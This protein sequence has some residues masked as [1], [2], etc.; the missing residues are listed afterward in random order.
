R[1]RGFRVLTPSR[2]RP[3]CARGPIPL[4]S[5]APNLAAKGPR[6]PMPALIPPHGGLP[7]PV[8][9]TVTPS[10]E[11]ALVAEAAKMTQ[12]PISDADL[13][14]VYRFGDGGLSPLTGPMDGAT[15]HR[16]LDEMVIEQD[17]RLYAWSIPL[18]VPVTRELAG[19]IRRGN[20][21][22]LP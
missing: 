19:G 18:S 16:A 5:G 4:T 1:D 21:I 20:T 7:E 14:T 11:A 2:S 9:C 22:A 13:S 6:A 15:Y 10:E 8:G 12:V 3:G 17:G